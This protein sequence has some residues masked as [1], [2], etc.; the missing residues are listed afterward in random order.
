MAARAQKEE[1]RRC[2]INI[3]PQTHIGVPI[4]AIFDIIGRY[5]QPHELCIELSEQQ[6]V[7]SPMRLRE[8]RAALRS[9]GIDLALDDVGF[10]HSSL[11]ALIVLEPDIVKIDRR[12]VNG[13]S[14]D[15]GRAR[16]LRRLAGVLQGLGAEVIAEGVESRSDMA[17][18]MSI[19][20]E[21]A[22]GYFWDR[23]IEVFA[24]PPRSSSTEDT[25]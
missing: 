24:Y 12:F 19:G 16:D 13:V 10:G 1:S 5:L 8:S 21:F 18:L 23:P 3:H 11:E 2:H 6:L 9:R 15:A 7:G 25:R 14:K 4:A 20:V 17:A 22:Q